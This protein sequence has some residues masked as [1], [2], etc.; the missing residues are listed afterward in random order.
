MTGR[1]HTELQNKEKK[2]P[3]LIIYQKNPAFI[4]TNAIQL[5]II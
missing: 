2:C 4:V 3:Y 1:G 5:R